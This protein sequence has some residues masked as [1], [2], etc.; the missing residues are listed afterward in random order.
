M[1]HVVERILFGLL[2]FG[3]ILAH[4]IV[5]GLNKLYI[6]MEQGDVKTCNVSDKTFYSE[7]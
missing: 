6:N 5:F 3:Q 2:D 4:W 1:P 7:N